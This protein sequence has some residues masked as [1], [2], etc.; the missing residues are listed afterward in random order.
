MPTS[1]EALELLKEWVKSDSLQKHCHAVA[2]AIE[3]YA[4]KL[5]ENKEEWFICGLLH[6]FDYER[7]PTIPAHVTEGII[8]LNKKGYSK[9]IIEAIQGHAEYLNVPRKSHMAKV[10]FAVDELCGLVMALAKVKPDN[11]QTMTAESVE[12]AMKKKGFAAAINRDDI[13]KGIKE[14]GVDKKEHFTLVINALKEHAKEL[15]F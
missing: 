12:K 10:L 11:F 3:A 14:L 8:V 13:E 5:G 1:E 7:F 2:F 15:G 4:E 9:E 6:D